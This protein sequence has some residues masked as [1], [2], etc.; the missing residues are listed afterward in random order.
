MEPSAPPFI[1]RPGAKFPVI[2]YPSIPHVVVQVTRYDN[3][4]APLGLIKVTGYPKTS[5]RSIFAYVPL[6]IARATQGIFH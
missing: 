3:L 1:S 5:S 6:A 2:N 4:P